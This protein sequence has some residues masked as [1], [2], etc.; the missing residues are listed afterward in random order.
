MLGPHTC[1]DNPLSRIM[2]APIVPPVTVCHTVKIG[3][4][5][6][7]F[8]G[9]NHN[10]SLIFV[11]LR[12]HD[13]GIERSVGETD[14]QGNHFKMGVDDWD[15]IGQCTTSLMTVTVVVKQTEGDKYPTSS[16]VCHS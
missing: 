4:L 7:F 5:F 12:T 3:L 13:P 14:V 16:L 6:Y 2:C 9:T 1:R 11:R 8:R 10:T 15:I